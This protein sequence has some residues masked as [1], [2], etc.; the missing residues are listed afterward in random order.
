MVVVEDLLDAGAGALL[1]LLPDGP[2]EPVE[3]EADMVEVMSVGSGGG[4]TAATATKSP[5]KCGK[6][7]RWPAPKCQRKRNMRIEVQRQGS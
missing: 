3:C 5:K 1:V 6:L 4:I 7:G 2:L